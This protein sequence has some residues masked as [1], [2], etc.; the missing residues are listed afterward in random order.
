MDID[1]EPKSAM[2]VD[3]SERSA[4]PDPALSD[5]VMKDGTS[6]ALSAPSPIG[7]G[8]GATQDP[9]LRSRSVAASA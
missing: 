5:V 7:G 6:D 3:G 8:S 2:D 9:R 4:I 1:E